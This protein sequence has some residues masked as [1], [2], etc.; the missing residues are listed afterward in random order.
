MLIS[1]ILL[2]FQPTFGQS[3]RKDILL[4]LFLIFFLVEKQ[5]KIIN[6]ILI[7]SENLFSPVEPGEKLNVSRELLPKKWYGTE[8]W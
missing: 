1:R 3:I 8:G 7:S 6:Y 4:V 5:L 2:Y